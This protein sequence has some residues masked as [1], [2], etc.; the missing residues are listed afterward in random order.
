MLPDSVDIFNERLGALDL[1]REQVH[2]L[3]IARLGLLVSPS[4]ACAGYYPLKVIVL[5]SQLLEVVF[6]LRHLVGE[7]GRHRLGLY[8]LVR[9]W[10]SGQGLL[11]GQQDLAVLRDLYRKILDAPCCLQGWQARLA[12]RLAEAVCVGPLVV[13]TL[14]VAQSLE[15]TGLRCRFGTPP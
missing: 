4:L 2:H 7:R 9:R 13:D 1:L 12:S 10:S 5:V 8:D 3:L 6:N 14:S 11:R 15:R